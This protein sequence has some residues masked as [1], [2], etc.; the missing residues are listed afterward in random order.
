MATKSSDTS[1]FKVYKDYNTGKIDANKLIYKVEK[2]LGI[3]T[4][5]NFKN[6]MLKHP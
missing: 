2:E 1:L 5:S 6:Y 3:K 4:N